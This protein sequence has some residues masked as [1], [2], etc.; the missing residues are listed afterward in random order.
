VNRFATD[1]LLVAAFTTAAGAMTAVL[2]GLPE[3]AILA[4][5]WAVL[6]VL[7]VSNSQ[8]HRPAVVVATAR[9]RLVVGDEVELTTTVSAAAGSIELTHLPS[10][11]FWPR[12]AAGDL[13]RAS[14]TADAVIAGG[15]TLHCRLPT[16]RWGTHDMGRV[17]IVLT[18]P[19]GLFRWDGVADNQ[20]M[21]RV[22][23][24]QRDLHEL[25]TPWLVRRI[26]GAHRSRAAGRGVEYADIR[27][28]SPGDSLRDINWRASGRSGE[29]W[30]SQRHPDQATDV[31]LLL[32]SFVESGHDA[33]T[34]VGLAIEAAVSLA[35]S[36]LAVTDRVGLVEF[37]GVVRWV[38]PG[39]GS[40]QLQRL[41]DAL[42]S[43]GLYASVARRPLEVIPPRAL[44][45][46]SFV[47]AL[48]PLLD[49]R[50]ITALFVLVARGHDVAVI[51]CDPAAGV[52]AARAGEDAHLL[53]RFWEAGRQVLR[54]R[55]AENGVAT[56]R[57]H[58]GG[59]LR[60]T[61]EELGRRRH[62]TVRAGR[63]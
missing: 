17:R 24:T 18:E 10:E 60:L 47:V 36:H 34:A 54:D 9:N 43:T 50:F 32:D 4:A 59:H 33:H 57:W 39:T 11:G 23:P 12:S 13:L 30:V 45:P 29:M 20:L 2:A 3:A 25:L 35:E 1:R 6:L 48:T 38:S 16:R 21:V 52:P 7:G 56:A 41:I 61:L 31:V 44:P 46:R 15:A 40:F 5:P 51:E 19:Y 22:H 55:L 58:Q 42:L 53:Q 49:E 63:R 62:R 14:R 28:F 26:T 8:R 37:G 27:P